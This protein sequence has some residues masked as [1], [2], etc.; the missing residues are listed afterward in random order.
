MSASRVA[1]RVSVVPLHDSVLT[2]GCAR[3]HCPATQERFGPRIADPEKGNIQS[4]V[5]TAVCHFHAIIKSKSGESTVVRLGGQSSGLGPVPPLHGHRLDPWLG[6]YGPPCATE[7][8][9]KKSIIESQGLSVSL[10]LEV[11]IF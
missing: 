8:P 7:Q 3:C 5:S 1:V 6:N 2:G 10:S 4:I 9:Q 11:N